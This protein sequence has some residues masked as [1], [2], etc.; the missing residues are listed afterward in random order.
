MFELLKGLRV[1]EGAS[2]IAGPSCG[3]HLAQMGAEVIRFDQIGGGPDFH[4]WPRAAGN[5]ASLYWEGLNKGKKSIAIDL[6]RPE[7]RELAVAIAAAPGENAGLFVTNFPVKGFLSYDRLAAVRK[8]ILCLRVMGWADGSQALDYTIN[9]A[10]GVPLVT[11]H[12]D[13]PRPVNHVLPAWD[14][15]TGAY[16]A[17]ALVSAER[18][19][20]VS[21]KGRDLRLSLSDIAAVSL[22]HVGQLAEVVAQGEDRPRNG[23]DL[24]GAFGRD[25]VTRDGQRLMIVAITARQWQALVEACKL[26]DVVAALEKTLGV[27]FAKDEGLRYVHRAQLLPLFEAAIAGRDA[28]ELTPAFEALGVCWSRYQSLTE[29]VASE[30]RLFTDN[31][32]FSSVTHPSGGTYLTPGA[33]VRMPQDERLAA[34]AAPRLGQHTDEVL[35]SVLNLSSAEI[36]RL[37]DQFIVAGA[38]S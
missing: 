22:A 17:F 31:P 1:V 35:S 3:L 29:A 11:G 7:G 13:D 14:L 8:D 36:G 28:A 4:R 30:P 37:H 18:E 16:G 10:V 15:L 2:F 19:R 9:A 25:F 6:S 23:N 33:A 27:S 5:G 21:G 24:F 38:T 26:G 12:P 20:R 32:I 34:A